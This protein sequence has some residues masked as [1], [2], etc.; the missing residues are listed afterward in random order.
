MIGSAH[1]EQWERDG[2]FLLRGFCPPSVGAA[3][4]A[5]ILARLRADPPSA[6]PGESAYVTAEGLVVQPEAKVPV[7][8]VEPEDFVAKLFNPHLAGTAHEFAVSDRAADVVAAILGS[9]IDVFQSMLI[10]KN[11]GAW[12]QPWHQD[13]LYFEF[14]RQPQ[15]GLWLA[16]SEARLDNGCLLVLPGSHKGPIRPHAPDRRPG[17]NQGYLEIEGVDEG[18]AVPVLMQPGDLLVFHSY[19]LH[20]S[21]DNMGTGRRSAMVYHYGR[22]GTVNLAPAAKRA[23]QDRVTRWVLVRRR[24]GVVSAA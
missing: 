21:V 15:V 3:M 10:L 14:D 13:S 23:I 6:H 20:K 24:E 19:L 9:D 8:A 17:A 4:E 1:L 5:E 7:G 11:P 2:F 12:G 18:D 16:I 22:A